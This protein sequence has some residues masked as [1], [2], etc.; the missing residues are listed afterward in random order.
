MSAGALWCDGCRRMVRL[1]QWARMLRAAPV[2]SRQGKRLGYV[3]TMR[4]APCRTV[5][6]LPT[7]KP[8]DVYSA[9]T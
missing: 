9:R 6:H 4:H 3:E 5:V 2:F 1:E 8:S 7:A